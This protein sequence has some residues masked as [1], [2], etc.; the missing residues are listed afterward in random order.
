MDGLIFL[1]TVLIDIKYDHH[2][3]NA[4]FKKV[5]KAAEDYLRIS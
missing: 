4:L 3:T 1:L 5:K 2:F